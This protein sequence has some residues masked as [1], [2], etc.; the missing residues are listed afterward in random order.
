MTEAS[1]SGAAATAVTSV[2]FETLRSRCSA[3]WAIYVNHPFFGA[4]AAGTFDEDSLRFWLSQDLLYVAAHQ[5][6]RE[7]LAR[8]VLAESR[9]SSLHERVAAPEWASE[10]AEGE[11][12]IEAALLESLGGERPTDDFGLRPARDAFINHITRVSWEG[13]ICEMTAAL[14]PCEAGFSEAHAPFDAAAPGLP[15]FSKRWIEYFQEAGTLEVTLELL[16]R[17]A[18]LPEFPGIETIVETFRRSLEHQIDVLDAA[19]RAEDPW[20]TEKPE[21]TRLGSKPRRA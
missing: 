10:A 7:R 18:E 16:E 20:P 21:A 14:L 15:E 19:W 13:S 3:A 8:R 4:I 5:R 9:L 6:V 12:A 1:N 11:L 2:S 17:S